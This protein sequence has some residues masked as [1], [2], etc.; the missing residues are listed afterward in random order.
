HDVLVANVAEKG[1]DRGVRIL[2]LD[3]AANL[4]EIEFADVE[5]AETRRLRRRDSA[6]DLAADGAAGSG[7]QHALAGDQPR[8]RRWRQRAILRP[9][10]QT[11]QRRRRR[12]TSL[13]LAENFVGTE[14]A[15]QAQAAQAAQRGDDVE[16]IRA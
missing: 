16:L 5:Q 9:A 13:P 10:E 2:L 1:F 15:M 4:V 7:D 12:R 3:L 6:R 11:G 8:L 14:F